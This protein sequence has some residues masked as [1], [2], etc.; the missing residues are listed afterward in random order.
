MII[1]IVYDNYEFDKRVRIGSGFACIVRTDVNTVLL[2][3]GA[4][5]PTLLHNLQVLGFSPC[6]IDT[7]VLSHIDSDHTGGLLKLLERNPNVTVYLPI[8]FPMAFK[9]LIGVNG[10]KVIEVDGTVEVCPGIWSSGEMGDWLKEQS[11]VIRTRE[12]DVLLV[13]DAHPG[14]VNMVDRACE[15]S[16]NGL[17]LVMGGMHMG[18]KPPHEIKSIIDKFKNMGVERVALCHSSGDNARRLFQDE[19]RENYIDSGVGRVM[20]WC[21]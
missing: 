5:G 4:H 2:D 3:T 1:A 17:H 14:I 15:I 12:G 9:N 11:L 7:I 16:G 8:S 6:E 13:G 10:A 18:G 21:Q 19:Y 20:S